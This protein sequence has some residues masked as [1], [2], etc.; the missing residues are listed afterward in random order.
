MKAEVVNLGSRYAAWV[1]DVGELL[2]AFDDAEALGQAVPSVAYDALAQRV[3]QLKYVCLVGSLLTVE[4]RKAFPSV[5]PGQE[6]A[7]NEYLDGL[8]GRMRDAPVR[9]QE[10]ES[11]G[12]RGRPE[13]GGEPEEDFPWNSNVDPVEDR[14]AS[15]EPPHYGG[16]QG[17]VQVVVDCYGIYLESLKEWLQ[18][19]VRG[20]GNRTIRRWHER[21]QAD[22]EADGPAVLLCPER[23][24]T[25]H[26]LVVSRAPLPVRKQLSLGRCPTRTFLKLTLLHEVGHHVYPVHRAGAI[27]FLSEALANWFAYSLLDARERALLYEKTAVQQLAY[28]MYS[29]LVAVCHAPSWFG[30]PPW[31]PLAVGVEAVARLEEAAF[32]GRLPDPSAMAPDGGDL[33]EWLH[34]WRHFPELWFHLRP[35]RWRYWRLHPSEMMGWML[36]CEA[37]PRIS[38]EPWLLSAVFERRIHER[39]AALVPGRLLTMAT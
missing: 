10:D 3:G 32:Q 39:G 37:V 27:R 31:P 1:D 33:L 17:R 38:R 34:Y 24:E 9:D 18:S 22:P 15:R 2:A 7:R 28:R 5:P 26:R 19:V 4:T 25:I 12:D 35:R 30:V 21:L 11:E 36:L 6:T 20:A 29:G 16:R 13:G 14:G 23:I 8:L